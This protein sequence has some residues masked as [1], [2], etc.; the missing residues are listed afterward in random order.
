MRHPKILSIALAAALSVTGAA[1]AQDRPAELGVGVFTFTSGP[2]AAYGMPGR[3]GAELIIEQI[4]AEGGIG[5]V[6]IVPT[7]VD[8]GQGAQGVISEYRRLAESGTVEAMIAALSSGNCLALAPVTEQL[9]MPTLAWNCDTH[10]LL[11]DGASSYYYRPNGNTIPEFMAYAL[12]FLAQNPDVRRVAFI[13]PDYS[14]GHDAAAIVQATLQAI[15]PEIEIVAE[16][17]PRLGASTYQ[18]EISRLSAARPDVIFSNL[19]GADLE[20][21]VRQAMPRGL[22]QQSTV[23]LALGETIL[24]T[25]DVPEGTI[26]GVLGDGYWRSPEATE[27][28]R[29]GA[30]AEA[31]RARFGED[32][33]FP[34]MKMVNAFL[35]LQAAYEKALADNGG[36]WPDS[37]ALIA[38]LE[39]LTVETMTGTITF[40]GDNDAPVDQ[41][42]GTVGAV[43][44][45]DR[46]AMTQLTR[47]DGSALMPPMGTDPIAW[48]ASLSPEF[49][50]PFLVPATA[51]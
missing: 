42:V 35:V 47:F 34:T 18:T 41:I 1:Q 24:Q 49:F 50:A 48:I 23:V 6:P 38:A 26:V 39:G 20:N 4:N 28:G 33:V 10:Q 37:A 45:V 46:P 2:A 21:F 16:L 3:Q 29:A 25:V 22:F 15:N 43:D 8:E 27:I 19:W 31:Y 5:G 9:Q 36:A 13:N 40:R 17:F 14:F 51:E 30:F 7:Y 44:G 32:P 12:Y 11:L